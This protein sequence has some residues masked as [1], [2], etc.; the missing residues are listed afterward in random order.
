MPDQLASLSLKY[1]SQF[2]SM[3]TEF[4]WENR[5]NVTTDIL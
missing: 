3:W 2:R 5:V 1:L 4:E